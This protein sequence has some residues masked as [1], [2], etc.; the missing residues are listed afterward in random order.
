[1]RLALATG[2]RD[3]GRPR[4]VFA[5]DSW[6]EKAEIYQL[7]RRNV[8]AYG[9]EGIITPLRIDSARALDRLPDHRF[10]I[11]LFDGDHRYPSVMRDFL[12]LRDRIVTGGIALFHDDYDYFPGVRQAVAEVRRSWTDQ[13]RVLSLTALC[14]PD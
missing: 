14:K 7:F 10:S 8:N 12:N 1:M 3:S 5:I 2:V 13:L 6:R 9:L 11:A 4:R